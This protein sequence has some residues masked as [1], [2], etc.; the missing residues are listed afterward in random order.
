MARSI[1]LVWS[2]IVFV[3]VSPLTVLGNI[4]CVGAYS[5]H[6]L[7][8]A[9]SLSFPLSFGDLEAQFGVH[10]KVICRTLDLAV[11]QILLTV[12]KVSII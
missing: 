11:R 5:V 9:S 6:F 2:C 12:R 10:Y 8:C 4:I 7:L 1:C 3:L